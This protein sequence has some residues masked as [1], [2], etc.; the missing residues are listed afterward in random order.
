[1]DKPLA[2]TLGDSA[3]TQGR[4]PIPTARFMCNARHLLVDHG[5]ER[6]VEKRGKQR[7]RRDATRHGVSGLTR[8]PILADNLTESPRMHRDS[9]VL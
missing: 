1:M 7:A 9:R 8:F 4:I 2:W 3:Q 5:E 6:C